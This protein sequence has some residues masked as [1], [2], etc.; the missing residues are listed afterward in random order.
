MSNE[1]GKS[2]GFRQKLSQRVINASI[3]ASSVGI[4]Y[5]SQIPGVHAEGAII[6]VTPIT[7]IL[8]DM[9]LIF[10]S[11]GTLIVTLVPT[12]MLLM[13]IGF[14]FKFFDKILAMLDKLV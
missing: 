12:L 9:G 14:V 3:A 5:L 7:G 13:V 11:F 1:I 6:N 4:G 8:G 2:G 10:P